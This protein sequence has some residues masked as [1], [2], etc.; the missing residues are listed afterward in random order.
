MELTRGL[1]LSGTK[2]SFSNNSS[3]ERKLLKTFADDIVLEDLIRMG[4]DWVFFFPIH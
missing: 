2:T 1:T 3:T 4:C